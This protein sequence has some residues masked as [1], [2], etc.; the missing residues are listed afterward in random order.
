MNKLLWIKSVLSND[1]GSSDEELL[2]LL[3][4]NGLSETEAKGWVAKRS[5]YLNNIALLDDAGNDIGI[6]KPDRN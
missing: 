1:E 6:Y 4:E 5:Y 3:A 2:A